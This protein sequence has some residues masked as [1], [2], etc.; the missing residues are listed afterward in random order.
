MTDRPIKSGAVG[1]ASVRKSFGSF[2]GG[3]YLS[4]LNEYPA[5]DAHRPASLSAESTPAGSSVKTIRTRLPGGSSTGASQASNVSATPRALRA[6]VGST[7]DALM[8][9]PSKRTGRSR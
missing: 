7:R 4:S 8:T 3:A 2:P 6:T 9:W 5:A 1:Q